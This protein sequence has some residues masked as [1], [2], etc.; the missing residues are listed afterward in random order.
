MERAG[1]LTQPVFD[2]ALFAEKNLKHLKHLKPLKIG[3]DI[4][5]KDVRPRIQISNADHGNKILVNINGS[6]YTYEF[7][8]AVLCD[9]GEINLSIV[10][11]AASHTP[12]A[13]TPLIYLYGIA[14]AYGVF[15]KTQNNSN[16]AIITTMLPSCS[17]DNS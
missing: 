1:L 2:F 7:A 10:P 12:T 15:H 11:V 8:H 6:E 4:V 14:C 9:A 16:Y 13:E 5:C 17:I 3:V